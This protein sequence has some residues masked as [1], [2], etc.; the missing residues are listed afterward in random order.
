MLHTVLSDSWGLQHPLVQ[1]PMAGV[2]G[3]ALARAVTSAG[4]LG[5]LG[6]GSA[7][8]A[9][10]IAEEGA[11]AR[12][13]GRFGAGLMVW[14][15][16]R[17]PE[18]LD[19]VLAE[20]PFAVLLS[21]G[22]V[23]PYVARVQAA[24]ARVLCQ[25]QNSATAEQAVAAGVD[26]LIAQG[27][28]AGG[29]TGSVGTLPL[30]QRVLEIGDATGV[31]VL[32]AGGLA[33]GRGIAGVLAMGAAGVCLGTRFAAT[34]EALGAESAKQAILAANE[35]QTVQTHVFDIIQELPWP[36]PFPGRALA[37]AFTA[38]WHGREQELSEHLTEQRTAFEAARARG[39]LSETYVY[40][41]QAVGLIEE[42][43]PAATLVERLMAEA[44]AT[45]ARSAALLGGAASGSAA[46]RGAPSGRR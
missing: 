16:E 36:D 37:N 15:L 4:G 23:T 2:S 10:W 38:R 43:L 35:T 32:A 40:A 1:A 27:T 41:G 46:R 30:L 44:E 19:L 31:P 12:E 11:R 21:F 24:G 14:A 22:D 8:P 28:E 20:R 5:M 29:H 9:T 7:T 42:V 18:L 34:V 6:I 39:D 26:A 17:R 33:S 25:V 45:L 3:G 13:G